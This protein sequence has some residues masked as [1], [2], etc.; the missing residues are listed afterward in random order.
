[1]S[2]NLSEKD[3]QMLAGREG[4]ACQTAMHILGR[5]SEVL[6]A[7]GLMDV[8]QAHIDSCGLLSE[9]GL[10][11][12]ETLAAQG[13]KVSIPTTLSMG[14]LDL[15]NWKQYGISEEFASKAIRQAKAYC[16]MGCIPIW[17]CAPYQSYLTPRFGQQI[18]WGESNAIAYANSVLGAR[19]NRY[20]DFMDICAAITG[21]VPEC[22]LHLTENRK[23]QI[24]LR[25]VDVKPDNIRNNA[26]Y[27]I[28]GYLVGLITRRSQVRI[29]SPLLGPGDNSR[30]F[31]AQISIWAA[32]MQ[33]GSGRN[34]V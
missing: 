16:D 28:L 19:T 17:T 3:K 1:M 12:A 5:M 21:R 15:Q 33:E 26:F 14:P 34:W 10:E 25:L 20:G 24:L 13:G 32:F 11:F 30:S 9:S 22:G 2:L 4:K 27:A 29:L 7:P 18:A 23:G 6:G 31:F 8:S